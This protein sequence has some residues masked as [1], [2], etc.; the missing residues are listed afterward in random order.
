MRKFFISLIIGCIL[1]GAGS[2]ILVFESKDWKTNTFIKL[3]DLGYNST[4]STQT[5]YLQSS[6]LYTI[7]ANIPVK[8]ISDEKVKPG[9]VE[10]TVIGPHEAIWTQKHLDYGKTNLYISV[11]FIPNAWCIVQLVRYSLEH[12]IANFNFDQWVFNSYFSLEVRISPEDY[13]LLP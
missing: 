3:Q 11:T 13:K 10:I 7:E 5:Y 8:V 6:P 2:A 4:Q 12:K 9:T 1:I